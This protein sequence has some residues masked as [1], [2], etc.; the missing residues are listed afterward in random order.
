MSH[1]CQ[2]GVY[3]LLLPAVLSELHA[4]FL[5]L[6]WIYDTLDLFHSD[7]AKRNTKR[8]DGSVFDLFFF[9]LC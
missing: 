9:P 3:E 6:M 5:F 8:E 2:R 1:Q 7:R 4:N